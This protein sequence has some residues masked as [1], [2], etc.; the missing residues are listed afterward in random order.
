M[1]TL[2]TIVVDVEKFF[3]GTGTDLEKFGSAFENLFDKAPS[4]LQA[5]QNFVG[6]VA[7]IV[8]AAVALADPAVEAPVAAVLATTETALA[9]LEASAQAAVSGTSVLSNL[10]NL[11][12]TV[13]ALLAGVDIKNATL[14]AKITAIV[15]LI[16]NEAKVLIPAVESWVTQLATKS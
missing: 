5:I 14:T 12:T 10:Q 16:N 3:K 13:P 9:A 2:S 6:E 7:P 1:S 4:A 8:E 15:N 11:A